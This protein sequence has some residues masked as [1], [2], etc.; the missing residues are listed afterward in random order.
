V[1]FDYD[2]LCL[3]SI[4]PGRSFHEA[5]TMLS[6]RR[7]VHRRSIEPAGTGT[8]ITDQV[9][10]EP[11]VRALGWLMRRVLPAV[12]RHRHRRLVAYFDHA[13]RERRTRQGG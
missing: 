12:F 5:S 6:Q 11:R 2:D 9:E 7:W 13:L 8:R 3:L 4:E 1:P 10:F